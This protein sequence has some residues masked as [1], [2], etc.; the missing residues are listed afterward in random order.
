M[1][2]THKR[3]TREIAELRALEAS[4]N[5]QML[6]LEETIKV[7]KEYLALCGYSEKDIERMRFK[8]KFKIF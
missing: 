2:K 5:R 1:F 7:A 8:N 6:E 3:I 4:I